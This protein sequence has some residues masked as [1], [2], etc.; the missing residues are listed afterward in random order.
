M[1]P[2]SNFTEGSIPHLLFKKSSAMMI[3][4]MAV[5]AFNLT[6]TYFIGLLGTTELA[7]ISFTFP[8]V[9]SIMA[10]SMGLG[11]GASTL[12]SKAIGAGDRAQAR[13]LTTDVLI[14][15]FLVVAVAVTLGFLL[16][17]PTFF[18]MGADEKTFPLIYDYM[19]I[20]Y[21]GMIFLTLPMVGNNCL[22]ATGDMTR[23]SLIMMVAMLVNLALDPLLIFG[24]GPFP[25]MGIQGAAV[26]TLV[27]RLVTFVVAFYL[28]YAKEG[29]ISLDPQPIRDLLSSFAKILHIAAPAAATNLIVP[30]G[31]GVITHLVADYGPKAVAAFGVASRIDMFALV[32][33]MALG[34]VIGP[35]MGQNWGAKK[36][37]RIESGLK[38]AFWFALTWGL[39]M[40]LLYQLLGRQ[41][42]GLFSEDP[43]VVAILLDYLLII[44]WGY[45]THAL[46]TLSNTPLNV[47]GKPLF[48]SALTL[49]HVFLLNIPLAYWLAGSY[50]L[51]GIF[52]AGLLA[53]V[54]SGILALFVFYRLYGQEKNKLLNA[55]IQ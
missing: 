51:T 11:I 14:L 30:L 8:V 31:A 15:S 22:R 49:G 17:K 3:G 37:T 43:Q 19:S 4:L 29:L 39:G 10:M 9:M 26:A 38:Q 41:I 7:A 23:P 54:A 21:A 28:L 34:S 45:G 1:R 25:A 20:W 33:I 24:M 12:I 50:Q 40:V 55:P 16:M 18:A 48:A 36:F 13:R 53:K 6:D 42:A 47:L 44:S 46:L 52:S 2:E 5:I 32:A 35:F 27:S